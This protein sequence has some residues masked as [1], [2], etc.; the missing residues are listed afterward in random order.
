[1]T[2]KHARATALA[3]LAACGAS[4]SHNATSPPATGT[5][6]FQIDGATCKGT[7][8]TYFEIDSGEVGP[9]I[10]AP[11]Q[12]SRGYTVTEGIHA[13]RARLVDYYGTPA[14]LWTLNRSSTVPANGTAT[15][16][17]AC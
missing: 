3:I 16:I 6:Y 9:E 1:M 12:T 10:L 5:L 17:V 15:T 11:T 13:T 4:C 14:D 8:S 2:R 7:H